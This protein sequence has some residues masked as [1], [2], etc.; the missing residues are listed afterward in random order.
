MT[1]NLL[2]RVTCAVSF[3]AA[4]ALPPTLAAQTA[5]G[6]ISGRVTDT[7]GL[8]VPGTTVTVQSPALQGV[9]ATT[10][11]AN[12]DYIFPQLPPGEY[13]VTFELSG[14]ATAKHVRSLAA[15]QTIA[16]DAT[17]SPATV[18]ETVT[19]S[20]RTD[21][22]TNSVQGATNLKQQLLATLPTTRT[23]LAAVDLAPG[24]HTTG[25]SG[26]VSIGGAM[27][28]ENV[29]LLN[30]V[31]IQDNL[32]GTPFNLFIE[33]A[34]QET[35]IV[36]SGISAEYG[37]FSGG[38]VNAVTRSGG[39]IFSGS[40]RTTFTNDDWRS[41]TPFDEPKTDNLVPIYEFT[42][43]GPIL[44][45]RTWFFG[46]GRLF[47]RTL[48]RQTGFSLL[49]F[50]FTEDEKRFEGKITQSLGSG[51]NIKVA[52][53][54]I[55]R[56][57]VN[58][59][60]PSAGAVMDLASLHT[61]QTPQ[62]LISLN[63]SGTFGSTFFVEG[64]FSNR[65]FAF[66]NSGAR[67]TDRIAG[68]LMVDDLTGARWWSPTFCGVCG[69]EERDNQNLFIK[70]NYFKST[71]RGAHNVTFGYDTFNDV[72]LA[73]NHQSGSDYR[74]FAS[75][76]IIRDGVVY[77]V[78]RPD[79]SS[80]IVW[81]PILDGSLGT[82][83]RTHSLFFNDS[84]TF[85]AHL[86]FN[87]GVR[88]DRNQGRDSADQLRAK[89]SAISPRVGL[90]W[91]PSGEGRW[92]LNA[93][94]GKYVAAVANS[95]ADAASAAGN[96]AGFAWFHLGEEINVDPN[97]PL[98]PTDEALR[99]LFASFDAAGGTNQRPVDVSVPGVATQIQGSLKS[100]HANEF[101]GG[102]SRGLGGRG[103][104][105]ADVIY[106]DFDDFYANRTD[107]S[108]GKVTST[109]GLTRTF[110]LT[111]VENTN[112]LDRR[113]AALNTQVNFRATSAIDVGGSYT[114]S[115]LWGNVVG[116][117][118]ASGPIRA[119]IHSYPEYFDPAW[120]APEGDLSSDQRHRARIWGTWIVPMNERLGR[121]TVGVVQVLQS[122]TPYGAVGSVRS[123]AIVGDLGYETPPDSVT[124][125]FTARDAFRTESMYRTDVSLNYVHRLPGATRGEFFAHAQVLNLFNQ[126]QLFNLTSNGINT[127]VL[128]AVSTPSRFQP[129]D[130]FTERPV[131]GVHW[132]YGSNFGNPTDAGA[133][134]LPR[135]FQFAV[136]I[137]F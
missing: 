68:T 114:L 63:Y 102:I 36:T 74:I 49:P 12:G 113:Y 27:S 44:R 89:D 107:Q 84:W 3:A 118:V 58:S 14:F 54:Q 127:T 110:D 132:D 137:R 5:S 94:Y 75:E 31:Q 50:D 55:S 65:D 41:V 39:N 122:G 48:A 4:C 9:R 13:T 86:T 101:A 7:G 128:S 62:R 91:D 66:K 73:N 10:T 67:S 21:A 60:F 76:T 25:P 52:Y 133:Y 95:I 131:Q 2:R 111:L 126:F 136:G 29:Y 93:S 34:I 8:A 64:Q 83:F 82:D 19:V 103:A 87:L 124:Y 97:G 135:T 99:S 22:F 78:L 105:R 32:R 6:T 90:V 104:V 38:V 46:A 53:T 24:A 80:F 47:D 56:E 15:A 33:D 112:A 100:P 77:P 69:P 121:T 26:N 23:L 35:T 123:G 108:T 109:I 85:N 134:T 16:L 57:E 115:R 51:H 59:A 40:F 79:F 37:R 120:N 43:G 30:G 72:R 125:Y 98:T 61:R 17:M 20:G 116:E 81:N 129:F 42:A 96:P 1:V 45:D 106:R 11:S 130:P 88:W 18:T 92:T 71:G 119:S 117:N 28:F 70:G